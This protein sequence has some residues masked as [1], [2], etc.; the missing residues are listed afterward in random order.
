MMTKYLPCQS[1][2]C[3]LFVATISMLS[4]VNVHAQTDQGTITGIVMDS[5]GAVIAHAD[6]VLVNV[7][8]GLVLNKRTNQDGIYV[9]SPLKVGNYDVS[10]SAPNFSTMRQQNIHLDIQARLNVVLVLKPAITSEAVTVTTEPEPLQTQDA[11]VGQVMSTQTINTLPLNGRNWVYIAQLT[12]G[13]APAVSGI[14]RGAGTGDFYANG[15]RATQNNFILDGVDNNVNV[16][17]FM[18]GASYNM[19]P[20]PDALS[21]FKVATSD[22][23]AEF[24]H[25]A[26][27]VLTAAIKSGTNNIHGDVWEYARNTVLDA[28]DWQA[29]SIPDY[30][31]N[32]FGATLGLPILK[33]RLFYFGD[34]EANRI[35]FG[36]TYTLTVPTPLMRQGN[37][38]ELLNTNLT[39]SAKPI[40][41]YQPN[42]G[43]NTLLTCNGQQNVFC[44]N[45]LDPLAENTLNMY[46]L[47]NINKGKTTN[48]FNTTINDLQRTWQWDQRLD[49]NVN[50]KDQAFVRLSYFH[51]QGSSPSPIGPILDGGIFSGNEVVSVLSEGLALSETHTVTPSLV[52]EARFGYNWGKFLNLQ[53]NYN[54]NVAPTLGFNN[55]PFGGTFKYNGGLPNL[56]ISGLTQVGTSFSVPSVESQNVYQLL[57]N[58][59]K[60]LGKHALKFGVSLESIR[61]AFLQPLISH[62]IYDY[63]GLYTSK[64]GASF[65]GFGAA[66]FLA[67][68]NHD[69]QLSTSSN[70]AEV[71]WYRSAYAQDDWRLT[72]K[73]TLNLGVRY[74]YYQPWREMSGAQANLVLLPPLGGI[75]TGSGIYEIPSQARSAPIASVFTSLL[76]ANHV[77]L[78]YVG[79]PALVEAQTT[80]FAPRFGFAYQLTPK[81]VVRGGFGVF[82]GGLESFG[83]A[84]LGASYPFQTSSSLAAP[85]CAAGKCPSTGLTLEN[86]FG[87]QLAVGLLNFVALPSM[88]TMDS[89][90]K[91]PYS[92]GY[93]LTVER[94]VSTSMVA[95]LAYVGSGARHLPDNGNVNAP[96]ALVN[97][98][99]NTQN[100]EPFPGFGSDGIV[101][102]VGQSSY[103]SLQAKLQKHYAHGLSYL[104]SYTYAHSIDNMFTPLGQNNNKNIRNINLIPLSHEYANSGFDVRHRFSFLGTYNLPFGSG[105][106]FLNRGGLLNA[107]AG[108]WSSS[109]IFQA[110]TGNPF[111]VTPNI[112]TAGGGTARTFL[113]GNPFAAGGA[114]NPTN[115]NVTCAPQIR[116]RTN[117]YNPCAFANPLP[118]SNIPVGTQVTG[119]A[120]AI[121]YLG[122]PTNSVYGPGFERVN[123]S[124]FKNLTVWHEQRVE[125]RTDVFNV[126][127]HPSWGNP[128]ITTNNSNGGAITG[129]KTFSN[130]TPDA[131][132]FQLSVKYSF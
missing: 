81:T 20:P 92:M 2:W 49:W 97:P 96:N 111:A 131:R 98:S 11:S 23:N 109:V 24:G 48:N 84:N 34:A 89:L 12:A 85:S 31:E 41:L 14:S 115:P 124:M 63:T 59:T 19:R 15:E 1:I 123:I 73:L 77:S 129:P 118:G 128:S 13:V 72:P 57:D 70:I 16:I 27:A 114:P 42:S 25:S 62:G 67:N 83:G 105:R 79:N 94:A 56:T 80:N 66:D 33:N 38:S 100:L 121:A 5:G 18:N 103:N 46:P 47:P 32:Q 28:K 10:A 113:A 55:V 112:S 65:T 75:G 21:E 117:W 9:F 22:F 132:F 58:V 126:L 95:S 43:G 101:T 39:G 108:G 125:F 110:E 50:P 30:S 37:F 44:A 7:D 40:L 127:N 8:T 82:Y 99:V 45:Q 107:I 106:R 60:I 119:L 130:F 74:E 69:A 68:Q 102:F 104:A 3:V 36:T 26:G 87:P 29:K 52:N 54:T 6:V 76:A 90:I 91:T 53:E 122:G 64:L 61:M 93:N 35:T 17:D 88:H 116:T 4:G 120:Q 78:Q 71:R 86:G 51:V